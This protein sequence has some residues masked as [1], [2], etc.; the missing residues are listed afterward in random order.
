MSLAGQR[1]LVTGGAGFLGSHLVEHLLDTREVRE[2]HEG[3]A[4]VCVMGNG[5]H[6]ELVDYP[7]IGEK[8]AATSGLVA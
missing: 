2:L 4:V 5:S 3:D 1:V 7:Q 6:A 8:I